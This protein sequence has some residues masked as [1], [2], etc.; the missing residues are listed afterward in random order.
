VS[1]IHGDDV[2]QRLERAGECRLEQRQRGFDI[3]TRATE[4]PALEFDVGE[5]DLAVAGRRLG[6]LDEPLA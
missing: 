4:A 3:A 5:R 1:G 6:F 2:V